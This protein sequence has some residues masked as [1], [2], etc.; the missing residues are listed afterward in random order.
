MADG[1][2]RNRKY[3]KYRSLVLVPE[4]KEAVPGQYPL[5]SPTKGQR[6]HIADDP[7]LI[8]HSASA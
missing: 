4:M 3:L 8:R 5:K 1:A 6:A 7:F 2:A